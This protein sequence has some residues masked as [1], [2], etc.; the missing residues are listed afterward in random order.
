MNAILATAGVMH[1]SHSHGA[2]VAWVQI[3]NQ[4]PLQGVGA[5]HLQGA[6]TMRNSEHG[7]R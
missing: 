6:H 5:S 1:D 7:M 4:G 3:H 2:S